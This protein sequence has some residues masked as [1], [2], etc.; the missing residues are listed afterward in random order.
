MLVSSFFA[1]AVFVAVHS[2]WW[3]E[4]FG[5]DEVAVAAEV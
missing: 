4:F 5:S 2:F 1:C 3:V